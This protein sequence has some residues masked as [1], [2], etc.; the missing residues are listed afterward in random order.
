MERSTVLTRF[1]DSVLA[2][3]MDYTVLAPQQNCC[4]WLE[5]TADQAGL[6]ARL[7]PIS[8]TC[9]RFHLRKYISRVYA[10]EATGYLIRRSDRDT[11]VVGQVRISPYTYALAL[12]LALL[13]ILLLQ[14]IFA[15]LFAL[16]F[17]R[18]VIA[19]VVSG[20]ICKMELAQ[21]V[22]DALSQAARARKNAVHTPE[23]D[24]LFQY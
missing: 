5:Q 22:E 14:S 7:I 11:I 15:L 9:V 20:S 24:A 6:D 1:P 3:P 21:L 4:D 16:L 2:Q 8:E 12:G 23:P 17:L 19:F 10:V 18:L 13:S